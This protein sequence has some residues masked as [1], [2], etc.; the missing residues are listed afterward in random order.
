MKLRSP[1]K[2]CTFCTVSD[3]SDIRIFM[4][5]ILL[6]VEFASTPS[7]CLVFLM[8]PRNLSIGSL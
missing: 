7:Q 4:C 6:I 1:Q 3:N 5:M 8:F 2:S